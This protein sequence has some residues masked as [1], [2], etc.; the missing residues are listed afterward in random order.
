[1]SNEFK[2]PNVEPHVVVQFIDNPVDWLP[3]TCFCTSNNN[4]LFLT[5][6][7]EECCVLQKEL[8]DNQPMSLFRWI[9]CKIEPFCTGRYLHSPC[10]KSFGTNCKGTRLVFYFLKK[11]SFTLFPENK[12]GFHWNKLGIFSYIS[13]TFHV[14][15]QHLK[16]IYIYIYTLFSLKSAL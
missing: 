9:H 16:Y 1:M 6:F 12:C 15:G 11:T 5:H 10:L 7:L 8:R 14:F 2:N 4:I 13:R 3:D